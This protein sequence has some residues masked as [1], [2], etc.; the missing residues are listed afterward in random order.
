MGNNINFKVG[1]SVLVANNTKEPDLDIDIGGWQGRISEL[2]RKN[3]FVCIEWD[4]VS[5]RSA[6]DSFFIKSKEL[7]L[8]WTHTDLDLKS[9]TP[10]APRDRPKELAAIIRSLED[11]YGT[12]PLDMMIDNRRAEFNRRAIA[13]V[14]DGF[15][16]YILNLVA[17]LP[18][19]VM[20]AALV[21]M[22][23][24][25]FGL[26]AEILDSEPQIPGI[27]GVL[28]ALFYFVLFEWL[29]SGTLGKVLLKIRVMNY[30]G[31]PCRV[32]QAFIRGLYRYIE[33]LSM[34][35]VAYRNMDPPLYQRLGDKM[36]GTIVVN[37]SDPIIK[38][39]P[40]KRRLFFA[41]VV[42]LL[43]SGFVQGILMVASTTIIK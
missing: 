25:V 12:S 43:V 36:A 11:R 7:G 22:I 13:F 17:F 39:L 37:T 8:D 23:V 35:I 21:G 31:R 9:I 41:I 33:G 32:R 29:H 5:L 42:Y 38:E 24:R 34:G 30:D 3:N 18:G 28:L 2:Y 19:V 15:C 10:A 6:P 40:S 27:L 26:Q 4:S 1:D 20:I 14:I 16:I